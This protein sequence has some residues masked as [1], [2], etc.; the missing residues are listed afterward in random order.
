MRNL[1]IVLVVL[2]ASSVSAD[3]F[4]EDG[5]NEFRAAGSNCGGGRVLA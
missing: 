4:D 2:L 5:A 1:G 3:T